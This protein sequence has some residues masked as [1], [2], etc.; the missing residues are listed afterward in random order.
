M[1]DSSATKDRQ[2]QNSHKQETASLNMISF[3]IRVLSSN[4]GTNMLINSMK[5]QLRQFHWSGGAIRWFEHFFDT[6]V[7]EPPATGRAWT[8][9][10]LRRKVLKLVDKNR[11]YLLDNV[12]I[13]FLY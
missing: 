4:N 11:F 7:N 3:G 10:D 6:N 13:I 5:G 12:D 9:P 8:V 2:F 1:V